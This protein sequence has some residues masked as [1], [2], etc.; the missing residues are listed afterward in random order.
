MTAYQIL[1]KTTERVQILSM[2]SNVLVWLGSMEQIV[3]AVRTL[4]FFFFFFLVFEIFKSYFF[5]KKKKRKEKV[6]L[7]LTITEY[8]N[9]FRH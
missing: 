2:N 9:D 1:A 4:Y 6:G 7:N 8:V 5:I 3:K